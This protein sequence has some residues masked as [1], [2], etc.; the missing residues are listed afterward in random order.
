MPRNFPRDSAD[1][2]A[3]LSSLTIWSDSW[4][5]EACR[6]LLSQTFGCHKTPFAHVSRMSQA[7]IWLQG[8][9]CKGGGRASGRQAQAAGGWRA[10][11]GL[12]GWRRV[13]WCRA[14]AGQLAGRGRVYRVLQAFEQHR[15][16][17]LCCP[18]LC[19]CA[20]S[21]AFCTLL[22]NIELPFWAVRCNVF[23]PI[24]LCTLLNNIELPFWVVRCYAP[25]PHLL[26]FKRFAA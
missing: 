2:P 20:A 3:I 24:V 6:A 7:P 14:G 9:F 10:G 26:H 22:R 12:A 16:T 4:Q 23:G 5:D 13:G 8:S 11:G 18:M 21:I 15:V 17:I 1:T 19:A 25:R